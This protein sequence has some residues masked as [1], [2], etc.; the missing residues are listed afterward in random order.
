M[1]Y[2]CLKWLAKYVGNIPNKLLFFSFGTTSKRKKGVE[3]QNPKTI[4]VG[5]RVV[6][7]KNVF[8]QVLKATGNG[9]PLLEIMDGCLIGR[10]TQICCMNGVKIEENCIMAGNCFV[11]DAT[12]SYENIDIP[13]MHSAVKELNC[14]VIGTGSWLGRNSSVIGC[15]IGKHCVVGANSFVTRDIPDYCVVVG[16]PCR[17]VKRYNFVSRQWEKTDKDGNFLTGV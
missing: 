9:K 11:A 15:K 1:I 14:V 10:N 8:L 6:L 17:I 13:V 3:L 7:Q 2:S 16:C 5:E 4:S 12:H